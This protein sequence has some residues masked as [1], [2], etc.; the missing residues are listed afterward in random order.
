MEELSTDSLGSWR[1][2]PLRVQVGLFDESAFDTLKT[3]WQYL[4]HSNCN[5]FFLSWSWV[6]CWLLAYRPKNL[7][8]Y[9]FYD[10][11]RLVGIGIFCE[12]VDYRRG[13]F[14]SRVIRL[15]QTG[16]PKED[17]IWVEYNGF[18]APH[19]YR[20]RVCRAFWDSISNHHAEVD[21]IFFAGLTTEEKEILETSVDLPVLESYQS[22]CMGVDLTKVCNE[23]DYLST[24]SKGARSRVRRSLRGLEELGSVQLVEASCINQ[25]L[26]F[27]QK[28]GFLHKKKWG[29][30]SGFENPK[31][32]D[33]HRKLVEANF[34]SG[35][36]RFFVLK[37]GE[38]CVGSFYLFYYKSRAY[39][40]LCGLEKF[41]DNKIRP[42][43][44]GHY[45]IIKQLI[46]D[47]ANYYDFMAGEERYK[48]SLGAVGDTLHWLSIQRPRVKFY[49]ENGLVALKRTV[50]G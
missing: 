42:G 18:L 28:A 33:F 36:V 48:E 41:D 25:A 43:L 35:V 13:F 50:L 1:Q 39:F 10:E 47:G 22:P 12:R 26:D 20:E 45:L 44:V 46:E 30:K 14:R 23:D 40:Y 6:G 27:F 16:D 19:D 17:Q 4:E 34:P 8:I 9:R 24:L 31:F 3:D 49:I 21:E 15:N 5:S 37:V 38:Q 2:Q 7:K 11:S 29:S 32:V